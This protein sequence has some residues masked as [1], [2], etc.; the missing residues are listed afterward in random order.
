MHA[1]DLAFKPENQSKQLKRILNWLSLSIGN[2]IK[3]SAN[4]GAAQAV[5]LG[6]SSAA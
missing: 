4:V 5:L 6:A 1:W 2:S 3:D